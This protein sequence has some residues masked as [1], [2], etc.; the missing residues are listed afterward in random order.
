MAW[1]CSDI[2]IAMAVPSPAIR[3]EKGDSTNMLDVKM[4]RMYVLVLSEG[5]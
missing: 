2:W 3:L 4:K 1:S 5:M